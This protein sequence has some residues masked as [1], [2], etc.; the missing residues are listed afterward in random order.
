MLERIFI[1]WRVARGSCIR[2]P[3]TRRR[4]IVWRKIYVCARVL[5]YGQGLRIKS[6]DRRNQRLSMWP[7]DA[8]IPVERAFLNQRHGRPREWISL[9]KAH[10]QVDNPIITEIQHLPAALLSMV[11]GVSENELKT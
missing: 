4:N 6:A 11:Y 1:S 10:A 8:C 9:L 2:K 3:G 5:I 7:V